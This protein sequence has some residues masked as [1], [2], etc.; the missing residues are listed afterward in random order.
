MERIGDR[1]RYWRVVIHL[2][3]KAG[4]TGPAGPGLEPD[5]IRA[6]PLEV[7][8]GGTVTPVLTAVFTVLE[9]FRRSREGFRFRG[10]N[11]PKNDGHEIHYD[12]MAY[13]RYGLPRRP[14]P[15]A[16]GTLPEKVTKDSPPNAQ[17]HE[18]GERLEIRVMD[19]LGRGQPV[20]LGAQNASAEVGRLTFRPLATGVHEAIYDALLLRPVHLWPL[21]QALGGSLRRLM[22]RSSSI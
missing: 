19:E 12:V 11:L 21:T 7:Y 17:R 20:S 8:G 14:P 5:T 2:A 10:L 3:Q 9:T 4:S 16:G 15:V 13:D 1:I 6:M 18:K 22:P